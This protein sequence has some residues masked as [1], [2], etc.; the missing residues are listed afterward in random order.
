M[1]SEEYLGPQLKKVKIEKE[2]LFTGKNVRCQ[3]PLL[4]SQ[5]WC[6]FLFLGYWRDNEHEKEVVV[7]RIQK[8]DCR[9]N[10]KNIIDRHLANSLNHENVLNIIGYE[11]D[12]DRW[13]YFALERFDATLEQYC[14]GEYTGPMPLEAN[15]LCQI[16]NGLNYLHEN[17]I[18]HG[19]LNPQAILIFGSQP[20]MMKVS[21]FGFYG[22]SIGSNTSLCHPKYWMFPRSWST[23]LDQDGRLLIKSTATVYG[24]VFAAGCLF[25]YFLKRGLHPFGHMES[26][27]NNIAENNPVNLYRL[28]KGHFAYELIKDMIGEPPQNGTQFLRIAATQFKNVKLPEIVA[29]ER[30]LK[31]EKEKSTEAQ[32][33][34][35]QTISDLHRSSES[36]KRELEAVAVNLKHDLDV[37]RTKIMEIT[38]SLQDTEELAESFRQKL[39][40][41][42][43]EKDLN[44]ATLKKEK[45]NL[46][47]ELMEREA[48]LQRTIGE[49]Q[50]IDVTSLQTERM[51]LKALS[52]LKSSSD[53]DRRKLEGTITNLQQELDAEKKQTS[54]LV[55]SLQELTKE[56]KEANERSESLQ[57]KIFVLEREVEL[58]HKKHEEEKQSLQKQL[59]VLQNQ[60]Q[61]RTVIAKQFSVSPKVNDPSIQ[62]PTL[63]IMPGS[64]DNTQ[65]QM[66]ATVANLKLELEVE[67]Q[68]TSLKAVSIQAL[69]LSRNEANKLADS[70]Q[71]KLSDLEIRVKNL[72]ASKEK[73]AKGFKSLLADTRKRFEK[74]KQDLLLQ[75][76]A[77][78]SQ[79]SKLTLENQTLSDECNS[80]KKEKSQIMAQLEEVQRE[81]QSLRNKLDPP[82]VE[83]SDS[84]L[85]DDR[86]DL[87]LPGTSPTS[88]PV[89]RQF[90]ETLR[91]VPGSGNFISRFHP[92]KPLL[93]CVFLSNQ[94][95]FFTGTSGAAPFSTWKENAVKLR[96]HSMMEI[97]VLEW[98]DVGNQLAAAYSDGVVIVWSYPSGKV[99]FQMKKHL[100]QVDQLEWNPYRSNI[101]ASRENGQKVVLLW[102]STAVG[103]NT[104]H[105][106]TVEHG[107][108]VECV[109]WISENLIAQGLVDGTIQ[110][111][112]IGGNKTKT[113]LVKHSNTVTD[114]QWNDTTLYFASCSDD[115][116]IKIWSF[117]TTIKE[118]MYELNVI[119]YCC[120]LAWRS[121]GTTDDGI[122]AARNSAEN[123]TVACGLENGSI[124]IW[125]PLAKG[126]KHRMLMKHSEPVFSILFSP[127]ERFLASVDLKSELIIWSTRTWIPLFTGKCDKNSTGLSWLATD[128]SDD[129]A[130]KL[131]VNSK[132]GQVRVIE[133]AIIE[134]E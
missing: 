80:T 83:L 90:K 92:S 65:I 49:L 113:C 97:K 58:N 44:E 101:F 43:N 131:A 111:S 1:A 121:N 72:T 6:G 126:R 53:N 28:H 86:A 12:M 55:V 27:L 79:K 31:A 129:A 132:D 93:A 8:T 117:N 15:A 76:M 73:Q 3:N 82:L 57:W 11:E 62:V 7:R 40:A 4:L 128:S 95:T 9:E 114:L 46:E 69:T 94:V 64:S 36:S 116:W 88:A 107:K 122:E 123:F 89:E 84:D 66:E 100:K 23:I 19:N 106:S 81:Y 33:V 21:D 56:K 118:A 110:V 85:E 130:Y 127:N 47:K 54:E 14:N 74:E 98:N 68:R 24:D 91:Y 38:V 16:S 78:A 134:M 71:R 63:A 30:L 26:I 115:K 18:S 112:E 32:L 22:E 119:S 13:R 105:V 52:D 10:W 51:S 125:N 104:N 2:M 70:L 34:M 41:L 75:Q 17:G 77:M 35:V 109:K 102:N 120:C 133:F 25:F 50:T 108:N 5:S 61:E 99:L 42:K 103:S 29:L 124:V 48:I 87:P 20:L 45:I 60:L 59:L 37:E 96:G 67:K 39:L